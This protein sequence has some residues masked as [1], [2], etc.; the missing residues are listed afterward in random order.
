VRG[1]QTGDRPLLVCITDGFDGLVDNRTFAD[2]SVRLAARAFRTV[3][4][5]PSFAREDPYLVAYAYSGPV[6]LVFSPDL[7]HAHAIFA[8]SLDARGALDAFR[9]ATRD[10]LGLDLDAALARTRTLI[11]EEKDVIRQTSDL[12]RTTPSDAARVAALDDRL[13]AL[14]AEESS[15]FRPTLRRA[16]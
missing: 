16:Q 13:R 2:E 7:L 6:L 4:V 5:D 12:R 14:R 10:D 8:S 1:V 15:V 11:A 3:R 9:V